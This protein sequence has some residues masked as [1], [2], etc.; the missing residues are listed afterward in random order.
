MTD[1]QI[2]PLDNDESRRVAFEMALSM[3]AGEPCRI[4]RRILTREDIDNAVFAGYSLDGT[5][6]SAHRVC[7]ENF[8]ELVQTLP[9][10]QVYALVDR[11]QV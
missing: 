9:R 1:I 4:C 10:E 7:W 11:R 3:Y 5:A 2:V 6:R 8:V